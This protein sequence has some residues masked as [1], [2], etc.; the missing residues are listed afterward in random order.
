MTEQ[1]IQKKI[2]DYLES[3]GCYVVKVVSASKSG[4]SDLIGCYEGR[5]FAIEVKTPATRNNV[6]KLQEYNIDRVYEAG[7]QAIVK[8]DLDG[9][10]EFLVGLVT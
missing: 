5:F 1:Q 10:K 4:V 2:Y 8:C 3:E 9:L 6:S 7:G